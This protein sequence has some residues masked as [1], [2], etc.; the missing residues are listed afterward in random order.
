[1]NLA[2]SIEHKQRVLKDSLVKKPAWPGRHNATALAPYYGPPRSGANAAPHPNSSNSTPPA[3]YFKKLN[4]QEIDQRKAKSLCFNYDEQYVQGHLCKRLFSICMWED[5]ED[6]LPEEEIVEID[7]EGPEISLHAM[8]GL[9]SS[10]TMQVKAQVH[11]L[12]LLVLVDS[13]STHNFISQ[14]AAEQLGLVVQQ[15]TSLSISVAN[16]AKITSVG[17][18]P[19]T[20]FDIEGHAFIA[21]FLVIPLSGFDLVLGIKWLQLLGPILWEFQA[22]TMTFTEDHRQ[23]ILHDTQAPVPCALQ[24]VQ[25][26]STDN[27][28]LSQLL[29]EFEDIFQE[30][31]ALPPIRHCDHRIHLKMGIEPIVEHSYRYPH[32]QKDEIE[33]QCQKM[34]AQGFIQPSRQMAVANASPMS[35]ACLEQRHRWR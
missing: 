7:Q 13:G 23:I 27:C 35:S 25:V 24:A 30:P 32:L 9:R 29:T 17:I 18:S 6:I 2:R 21:N 22:L 11:H 15:Q 20:H 5:C 3:P 28:K 4:R 8:T 34:I 10:N 31:T 16:G 1:M 33:R 12:H 14:P 26:H 19:A